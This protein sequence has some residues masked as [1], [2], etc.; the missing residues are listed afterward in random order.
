MKS[1]MSLYAGLLL[2][3]S[4]F[5]AA[6]QS[7][8]AA[9]VTVTIDSGSVGVAYAGSPFSDYSVSGFMYGDLTTTTFEVLGGTIDLIGT[10]PDSV[11]TITSGLFSQDGTGFFYDYGQGPFDIGVPVENPGYTLDVT[12]FGGTLGDTFGNIVVNSSF[13]AEGFGLADA[14]SSDHSMSYFF[15]SGTVQ[16]GLPTVV[17]IPAAAWLFGSGLL[18]LIGVARRKKV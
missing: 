1:K 11:M 17:P 7:A 14:S 5:L 12:G 6:S 8:V 18:G 4:Y 10:G 13:D 15:W 9:P 16:E 3:S 2:G